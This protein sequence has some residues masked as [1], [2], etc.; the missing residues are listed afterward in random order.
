MNGS[1]DNGWSGPPGRGKPGR[2]P[3]PDRVRLD[4]PT[5][6]RFSQDD[7]DVIGEAMM[8]EADTTGEF[9][10]FSSWVRKVVV[11]H[12]R[13]LIYANRRKP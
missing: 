1:Q 13:R 7:L 12:A 3:L 9:P 2:K 8:I 5:R 6:L 4:K 11:D 10:V